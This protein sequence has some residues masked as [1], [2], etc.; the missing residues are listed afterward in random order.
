MRARLRCKVISQ[1]GHQ[2]GFFFL[3]WI[4]GRVNFSRLRNV[5]R[6]K[7]SFCKSFRQRVFGPYVRLPFIFVFCFLHSLLH[8]AYSRTGLN[9]RSHLSLV[10]AVG[11]ASLRWRTISIP[12][13]VDGSD[14]FR[15]RRSVESVFEAFTSHLFIAHHEKLLGNFWIFSQLLCGI[16]S[17]RSYY[18]NALQM[19]ASH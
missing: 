17:H 8:L 3:V 5:L 18:F 19:S 15:V 14:I 12:G 10:L 7:W 11:R 2:L 6:G 16:V 4:H 9:A 13:V 1:F